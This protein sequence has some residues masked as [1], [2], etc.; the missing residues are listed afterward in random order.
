M[1]KSLY[2][3]MG[4]ALLWGT[5]LGLLAVAAAQ[6]SDPGASVAEAC[7]SS[8]QKPATQPSPVAATTPGTSSGGATKGLDSGELA[9]AE[10]VDEAANSGL[11]TL[12]QD[13]MGKQP[14][15]SGSTINVSVTGAGIEL[16]GNVAS[17]RERLTAAR[18]AHSYAG[19]RKVISHIV[20]TERG[21]AGP[22]Q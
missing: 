12:I 21:G 17:S 10:T 18:L 22:P 11:Q 14:S 5:I 8:P 16:S 4:A 3:V 20:I 13:A 1:A 7:Q 9:V 6:S 15:L 19:S 2:L